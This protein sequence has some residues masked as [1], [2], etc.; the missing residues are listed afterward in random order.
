MAAEKAFRIEH[1]GA[2]LKI[3]PATIM[4][5]FAERA[6][7]SPI[8]FELIRRSDIPHIGEN[9]KEQGGINAGLCRGV[10]GAPDY[11]LI[12]PTHDIGY[13]EKITYGGAGEDEPGAK[14]E[15]DGLANTI[16][17]CESKHDHPAAQAARSLT[18]GRHS[19]FYLPARREAALCYANVPELFAK[20]W[21]WTSTQYSARG[22]WIQYF[23]VGNQL[24]N[25]KDGEF[26][27][28]AV[29]RFVP[30]FI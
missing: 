14:C 8:E 30:S 17:L 4:Q 22:A 12:V 6:S 5:W 1:D 2:V 3:P 28:R 20:K 18:V 26:A 24:Y 7:R 21:H 27:A 19:D 15:F 23:G 16:A 10:N 25:D 29:R 13:I 11:F 9:W